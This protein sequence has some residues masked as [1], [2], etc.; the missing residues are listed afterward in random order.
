MKLKT[1]FKRR[2]VWS[3]AIYKLENERDIFELDQHEPIYFFGEKGMR[4]NSNYQATTADPFLFVYNH[5]LYLF[6]EVQ[7]DFSVGEI[8]A[9][10]MDA[11]GF[12]INHGQVLK[13]DFHLSYPQVFFY[14]G[15]VCMIPES[16]A[17]K[18]VCLYRSEA[19]PYNWKKTKVL[20]D[21]ILSDT[22]IIIQPEGIFLLGT[23]RSNELKLYFAKD[24]N[25]EFTCIDNV[26]LK[27]KYTARNAGKPIYINNVLY[28]LAQNNKSHYGEKI[29][30]LQI[31]QLSVDNYS[32]S[33]TVLDLYKTKPKWMKT[34]YHHISKA[35]F[36]NECFVAVDGMRPDKHI[37]TMLLAPIK[38]FD[39]IKSKVR[40]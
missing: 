30:L 33:I 16:A 34:G 14:D 4:L 39:R 36:M 18:Q 24:F 38:L 1:L 13:E 26:T 31:D 7:T 35:S 8:W 21:A 40:A 5:R 9:Q 37:N 19:F 3:I 10:S 20:I 25:Q 22:S 28:R 15:Q 2:D 32:E 23:T 11:Q 6:Y 27:N 17:S 29:T 12:W